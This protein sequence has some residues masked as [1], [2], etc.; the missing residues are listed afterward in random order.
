[1][2]YKDANT[3][4][5]KRTITFSIA[6]VF[7]SCIYQCFAKKRRGAILSEIYVLLGSKT[8]LFGSYAHQSVSAANGNTG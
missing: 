7:C 3:V 5:Q 4:S 6:L 1:M 8:A 2:A